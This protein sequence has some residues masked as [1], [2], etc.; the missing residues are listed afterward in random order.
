MPRRPVTRPSSLFLPRRP[1]THPFSF[2]RSMGYRAPLLTPASS[3]VGA[4]LRGWVRTRVGFSCTSSCRAS[5]P[6]TPSSPS[7]SRARS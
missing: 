7:I 5:V 1:V 6:W 2:A 3:R 4:Y